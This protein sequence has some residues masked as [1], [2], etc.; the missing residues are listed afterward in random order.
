MLNLS[1][2]TKPSDYFP[3]YVFNNNQIIIYPQTINGNIQATY[4][5]KPADVVWNFTATTPNF[6]Y[7]W[8]PTTSV[9]F[10][11]NI[12][13]QSNVILQILLYAGVVIK[14]PM[15]IQAASAEIQQEKQNERN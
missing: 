1:T 10:E 7:V 9:D 12:T 15:I 6:S 2:I 13:E 8:D 4:V 5:R 14:D 3:V 11:L